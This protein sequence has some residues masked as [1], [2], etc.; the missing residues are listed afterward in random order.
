MDDIPQIIYVI[1]NSITGDCW[2]VTRQEW[3]PRKDVDSTV[4]FYDNVRDAVQFFKEAKL[5]RVLGAEIVR[6]TQKTE[7]VYDL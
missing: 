3:I 5:N 1:E 4:S 7:K 2:N 6:Y